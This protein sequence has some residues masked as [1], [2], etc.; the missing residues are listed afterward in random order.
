MIT[1]IKQRSALAFIVLI[2]LVSLFADMTYEGA[3]SVAGPYLA[4]LGASAAT[5]GIVAG[6]GEL[7]GYALRLVSG[8]WSDQT[9]RYW[10]ITILGYCLNLL[11]VPLLAFAG[12][13][14]WASALLIVER[15]GKAVRTPARDAM[16]SHAVHEVGSGWGFGLHQAMDQVGAML[17]PI[18][19]TV[20]LYLKGA[21]PPALAVLLI[22]ALLALGTLFFARSLYPRPADLE[23]KSFPIG[24]DK[25]SKKFWLYV[26]AASCVAVGYADF[27]LIAFH[28]GKTQSVPQIWIPLFYSMAMGVDAAAALFFG[29]CFDRW[30]NRV[31][32][33]SALLS[34]FFAPFVFRG[35]FWAA[36][37]GMS[38]WGIGMG[39]HESVMRAAI[40][41]MISAK[42]RGTAFG[43]FNAFYGI[44]WFIGSAAMGFIYDRSVAGVI[45]FSMVFQ[46]AS[47]PFF[48]FVV[49]GRTD[50][51]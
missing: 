22:P 6:A 1:W 9:R 5:V 38:L 33:G 44:A 10:F 17:G 40:S 12:N 45:I 15:M 14:Q 51:A 42:K 8:Y 13:W 47:I 23:I 36:L 31:L 26:I 29:K 18:I 49:I 2:G 50:N 35:G 48:W 7:I 19:V 24:Q 34:L 4:V 20:V 3:R 32:I 30:G 46:A 37:L 28:F 21:Y 16:L 25:F 41:R 43:L 11:A 39:A 27:P